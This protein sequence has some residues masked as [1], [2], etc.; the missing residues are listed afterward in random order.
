[1]SLLLTAFSVG[2]SF[3]FTSLVGDIWGGSSSHR[4]NRLH[5]AL[6]AAT[7]AYVS[8]TNNSAANSH[9]LANLVTDAVQ[10]DDDAEEIILA[11]RR[12]KITQRSGSY[13]VTLPLSLSMTG[14]S[15]RHIGITIR[16]FE[17]GREISENILNIDD[18]TI[19][20]TVDADG[21]GPSFDGSVET[22]SVCAM[23]ERLDP[24]LAGLYVSSVAV[25]SP[26][27]KAGVRPGD[28][29]TSTAITF[30]EALWPKT[31]LEGVRSALKSRK[32]VSD[33]ATFEFKRTAMGKAHNI[34]ELT[35][36]RPIGLNLR[37]MCR[38]KYCPQSNFAHVHTES[39]FPLVLKRRKT[40][41]L[42]S[43]ASRTQP[44]H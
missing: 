27:W 41:M 35:V 19:K 44:Q 38:S 3:Q 14:A 39:S 12:R 17:M 2:Y 1:V 21:N 22:I 33:T 10:T 28:M 23:Q 29:L 30:G 8:S 20:T 31:T 26:A 11:E 9:Y 4:C 7:H 32:V 36:V 13:R 25:Q 6:Q 5:V 43:A 37:G 18:L 16:Q 15:S 24:R 42:K 40:V 34:Y